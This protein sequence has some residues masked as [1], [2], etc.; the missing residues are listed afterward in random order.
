MLR[1]AAAAALALALAACD[2]PKPPK[3]SPA[4]ERL[5]RAE[6]AM[7]ECKTRV[8]LAGVA[9]PI[10][11]GAHHS[12]DSANPVRF[13]SARINPSAPSGRG[14]TTGGHPE[15]WAD[16]IREVVTFFGRHLATP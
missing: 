6:A 15:A 14:A 11:P 13:V 2:G 12:F 3:A 7:E 16:S 9:T 5:T 1:V 10:Y 4:A 8:G